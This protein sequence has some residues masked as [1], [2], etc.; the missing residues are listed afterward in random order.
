MREIGHLHDIGL[1]IFA[2]HF[3]ICNIRFQSVPEVRGTNDSVD[4]GEDNQY[5]CDHGKR[6]ESLAS[7]QI[8]PGPVSLLIHANKL[9]EEVG[10]SSKV[11]DLTRALSVMGALK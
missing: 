1:F 5:D 6:R 8:A 10:H 2:F 4:D 11:K 3:S 7:R 9:E